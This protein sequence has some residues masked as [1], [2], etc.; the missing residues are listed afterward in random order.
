LLKSPFSRFYKSAMT[1]GDVLR[2]TLAM[3]RFMAITARD[4]AV[5][6]SQ[7]MTGMTDAGA[8]HAAAFEAN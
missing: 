3:A 4:F 2:A 1:G 7:I 6:P 5:C 8:N